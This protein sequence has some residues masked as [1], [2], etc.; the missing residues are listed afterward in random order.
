MSHGRAQGDE[1]GKVYVG[2]NVVMKGLAGEPTQNL[3]QEELAMIWLLCG[4]LVG[5]GWEPQEAEMS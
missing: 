5:R 4:E 3:N 1:V 2:K